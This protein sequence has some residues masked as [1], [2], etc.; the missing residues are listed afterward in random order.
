[1]INSIVNRYSNSDIDYIY[2]HNRRSK[3]Q[4]VRYLCHLWSENPEERRQLSEA[5]IKNID[6]YKFKNHRGRNMI[7]FLKVICS[8]F[9]YTVDKLYKRGKI[10]SKESVMSIYK[11]NKQMAIDMILSLKNEKT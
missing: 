11:S 1:M 5:I 10:S 9:I 6:M 3:L 7:D 2:K 4:K 8:L